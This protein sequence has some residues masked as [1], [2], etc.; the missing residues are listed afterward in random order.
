M[1]WRAEESYVAEI[2]ALTPNIRSLTLSVDVDYN[3]L[4]VR[5]TP[6]ADSS[7]SPVLVPQLEEFTIDSAS[8]RYSDSKT[9]HQRLK[10]PYGPVTVGTVPSF[11]FHLTLKFVD[12]VSARWDEWESTGVSQLKKASL[13]L[14]DRYKAELP[15]VERR[16]KWA[17]ERGL[18]LTLRVVKTA[19]TWNDPFNKNMTHWHD[20]LIL[21]ENE[22]GPSSDCATCVRLAWEAEE[23][24]RLKKER[25]EN[26]KKNDLDYYSD[27]EEYYSDSDHY[28]PK[29]C[30]ACQPGSSEGSEDW[31]DDDR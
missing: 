16:L 23:K 8:T 7:A 17:V 2:L 25:V 3:A 12:M 24:A 18:D 29:G 19:Q 4:L 13:F 10:M 26:E 15:I 21:P 30:L 31:F 28:F 27:S 22:S 14:E 6:S 11:C 5:L 20:G 1:S 9:Y